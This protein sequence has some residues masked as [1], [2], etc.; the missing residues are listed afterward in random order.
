MK[1]YVIIVA[2]ITV[3]DINLLAHKWSPALSESAVYAELGLYLSL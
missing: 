1:L 2:V 3:H